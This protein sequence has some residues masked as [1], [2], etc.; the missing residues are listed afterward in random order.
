M[1]TSK[2]QQN[3]AMPAEWAEQDAVLIAWP[4]PDT[5]WNYMLDEVEACYERIAEAI[6]A[7]EHLIIATPH[8]ADVSRKLEH[9]PHRHR[10]TIAQIATNDT[11]A[12]DF[13]PITV[14]IDG[15]PVA[16][17]FMFNGWGLKFASDKDNLINRAIKQQN[18]LAADLVNRLGFVL[19]GGS[20]ESD[21]NGTILTT[22]NCLLSPNRNGE[23][24]KQDI[25]SYIKQQFGAR[26]VLWVDHGELMGDDTDSHIDTLARFLPGN[27]IAYTRCQNSNDSHYDE[28]ELMH[29]QIGTFANADGVPYNLV[30]LP[31]PEPI[32]D[33]DGLRLPATYANFLITNNSLLVPTYGQPDLDRE[34]L[35][36]LQKVVPTHK[37]IG[38]DCR[39]LIKQHGS[40]HCVTM[41]LPAGSTNI[42]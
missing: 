39:A 25:E 20:I 41:Q 4:H 28:L 37:V 7:D 42:L 34:A 10:I 3:I 13:G 24:G 38:I 8:P 5:D 36:A 30:T 16:Y 14:N 9:L 31:L 27:T 22:S 32:F 1:K 19:E 33:E 26:Q 15:T 21:G 12:R 2:Q 11:W 35:E 29:E 40:L 17:D 18:L 23:M 6:S